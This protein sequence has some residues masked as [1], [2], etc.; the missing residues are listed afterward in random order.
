VKIHHCSA[1]NFTW[2]C[3]KVAQAMLCAGDSNLQGAFFS[4][5]QHA[6]ELAQRQA[7]ANSGMLSMPGSGMQ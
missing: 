4:Y 2:K 6:F 3:A 5:E 1:L 7:L